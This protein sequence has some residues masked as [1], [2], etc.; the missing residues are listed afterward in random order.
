MRAKVLLQNLSC[1]DSKRKIKRNLGKI[2]DVRIIEL[3]IKNEVLCF[4]YRNKRGFE[5]VKHELARIGFPIC[6]VLLTKQ[7]EKKKRSPS[8]DLWEPG[9]D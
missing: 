6:K 3:D 5:Q 8:Y 2:M 1:E 7:N 9:F 4:L